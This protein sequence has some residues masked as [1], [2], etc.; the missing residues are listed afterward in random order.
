MQVLKRKLHNSWR[1]NKLITNYNGIYR[2]KIVKYE[3]IKGSFG[4]HF[5]SNT[6]LLGLPF[7]P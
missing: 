1:N 4:T 2:K 5:Q 7:Q 6:G 3:M